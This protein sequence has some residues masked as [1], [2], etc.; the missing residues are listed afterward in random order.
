MKIQM[1]LFAFGVISINILRQE[2]TDK[3]LLDGTWVK[4]KYETAGEAH[5]EF[6]DGKVMWKWLNN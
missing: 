4:Y 2:S 3:H 5:L 6:F 1:L